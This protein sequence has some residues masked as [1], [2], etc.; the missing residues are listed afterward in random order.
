[1]ESTH[2]LEFGKLACRRMRAGEFVAYELMSQQFTAN[3]KTIREKTLATTS[4]HLASRSTM[5]IATSPNR[6][7]VAATNDNNYNEY[8]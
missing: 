8:D 4:D 1:M 6:D 3:M 5:K 7:I 2:Q